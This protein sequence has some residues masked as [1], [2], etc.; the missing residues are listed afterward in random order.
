MPDIF[1][2]FYNLATRLALGEAKDRIVRFEP[3]GFERP[4]SE[5]LEGSLSRALWGQDVT[6]IDRTWDYT[7]G[8]PP[9]RYRRSRG[10]GPSDPLVCGFRRD[11]HVVRRRRSALY[12]LYGLS[13]VCAAQRSAGA[14]S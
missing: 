10:I 6:E 8:P 13:R 4:L 2:G 9:G 11:V 14:Q 7:N 1:A 12:G 3:D 5:L